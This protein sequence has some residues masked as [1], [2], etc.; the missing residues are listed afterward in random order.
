MHQRGAA[1]AK[2]R[3]FKYLDT[4][5][6]QEI[7][8]HFAV[9]FYDSAREPI[10]PFDTHNSHRLQSALA[11]PQ[12]TFDQK[13]LYPTLERKAAALFYSLAKNHAF[14]NG[15]KRIASVSLPTF[16]AINDAWIQFTDEAIYSLAVDVANSKA[17]ESAAEI[18]RIHRWVQE[19]IIWESP[20]R[21]D[22]LVGRPARN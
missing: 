18:E 11:Q 13:D 22:E 14:Q 5:A 2:S 21:D 8:H 12:Q 16:L 15:N 7:C 20:F 19:R 4:K 17:E 6:M 9:K 3:M 1:P 10:P